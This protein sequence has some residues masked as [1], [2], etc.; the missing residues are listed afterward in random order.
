[1]GDSLAAASISIETLNP[2]MYSVLEDKIK[3]IR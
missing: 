3:K 1:M 2:E